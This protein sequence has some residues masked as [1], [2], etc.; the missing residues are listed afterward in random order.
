MLSDTIDNKGKGHVFSDESVNGLPED[1]TVGIEYV[2]HA[3]RKLVFDDQLPSD[4][5]STNNKS[6]YYYAAGDDRKLERKLVVP[7]RNPL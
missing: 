5:E 4:H 3:Q 2:T 1:E 7:S 6:K